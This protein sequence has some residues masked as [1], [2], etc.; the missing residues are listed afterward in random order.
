M[1]INKAQNV[2]LNIY[3]HGQYARVLTKAVSIT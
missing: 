1:W 3:A 2:S